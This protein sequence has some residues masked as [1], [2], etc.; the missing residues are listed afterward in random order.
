MMLMGVEPENE[1]VYFNL[2]MLSMDDK[3]FEQ[4]KAWFD[5]AIEVHIFEFATFINEVNLRWAQLVLGWVTVSGFDPRRRH[6]ISVWNQPPRSTQPSTLRGTV[7][8]VPAKGRWCSAAG[9]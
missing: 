2:G 4:A 5:R 1:K 7:K 6:F 8:W 9:E 3:D